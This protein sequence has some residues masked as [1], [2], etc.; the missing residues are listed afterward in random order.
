MEE[1]SEEQLTEERQAAI[2]VA[3]QDMPLP[4]D[5]TMDELRDVYFGAPAVPAQG[6][7]KH[8]GLQ[9]VAHLVANRLRES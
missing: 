7:C 4:G 6:G 1:K 8:V 2:D 3:L 9:A 5:L